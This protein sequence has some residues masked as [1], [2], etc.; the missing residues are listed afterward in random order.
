MDNEPTSTLHVGR[1][2]VA[3]LASLLVARAVRLPEPY[4]ATV[5]TLIV[6]QSSLV[7]SWAVSWRRLV[8]T[9]LGALVG[10][11]VGSFFPPGALVFAAAILATGMLCHL[12]RFDRVEFR[13]AGVTLAIIMLI[14]RQN[15]AWVVAA[16]RFIEVSIGVIIALLLTALWPEPQASTR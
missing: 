7:A 8:G 5:T 3:A 16:H 6:M 4:W 12:L 9:V 15:L 10:G 2:T 14:P 1:T 13:F 11:A